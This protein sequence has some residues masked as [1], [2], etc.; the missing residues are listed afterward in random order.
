MQLGRRR[1]SVGLK[2]AE[3]ARIAAEA[4]HAIRAEQP[5]V[6]HQIAIRGGEKVR[7]GQLRQLV[8]QAVVGERHSRRPWP[9][10]EGKLGSH[11][12]LRSA[13]GPRAA[14]RRPQPLRQ[15]DRKTCDVPFKSLL[16][17]ILFPQNRVISTGRQ[18]GSQL[19]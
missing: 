6:G 4:Q 14:K 9:F 18:H 1:G 17:K 10:G 7:V 15:P 11:I 16:H 3:L 5:E 8:A 19:K 13:P 2:P 12:R